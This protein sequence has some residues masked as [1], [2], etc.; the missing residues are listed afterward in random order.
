MKK[1]LATAMMT[2][3]LCYPIQAQ[4]NITCIGTVPFADTGDDGAIMIYGTWRNQFTQI[5]NIKTVWKGIDPQICW[6]W[7]AQAN[8]AV[9]ESRNVAVYYTDPSVTD[10][11]T[12]SA[13]AAAPAPET[14]TLR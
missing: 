8:S 14:I 6:A 3:L 11:A 4:A 13:F 9:T 1:T 10:C 7:F 12:I 2:A 5:C